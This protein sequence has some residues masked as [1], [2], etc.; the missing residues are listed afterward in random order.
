MLTN[1]KNIR[2]GL[3][4]AHT[5]LNNIKYLVRTRKEFMV[6]PVGVIN[7]LPDD[8]VLLSGLIKYKNIFSVEANLP[9]AKD[10]ALDVIN[11]AIIQ[12][13]DGLSSSEIGIIDSLTNTNKATSDLV[14]LIT[15]SPVLSLINTRLNKVLS[16][17]PYMELTEKQLNIRLNPI[18][19]KADVNTDSYI[20]WLYG[21]YKEL[22]EMGFNNLFNAIDYDKLDKYI[23][24]DLD[25]INAN[26]EESVVITT[27]ET[28]DHD[29]HILTTTDNAYKIISKYV[30]KPEYNMSGLDCVIYIAQALRDGVKVMKEN[31]YTHKFAVTNV[32]GK[33]KDIISKA[34]VD[35]TAVVVDELVGFTDKYSLFLHRIETAANDVIDTNSA[36]YN[37]LL[38]FAAIQTLISSV[39]SVSE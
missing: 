18:I 22:E 29:D 37:E 24:V 30:T 28:K 34:V 33:H 35:S 27:D 10:D 1:I 7:E 21:L 26:D 8:S 32:A 31:P 16:S 38:E 9:L 6:D 19:S 4:N 12:E 5:H 11:A 15:T 39:I 17:A 3:S 13:L 2:T 14:R 20:N 25:S 23:S 36:L